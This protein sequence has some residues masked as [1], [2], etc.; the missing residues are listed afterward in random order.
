MRKYF[1][2]FLF[3]IARS[4]IGL[5]QN[6]IA[7]KDTTT[8]PVDSTLFFSFRACGFDYGNTAVRQKLLLK[9]DG[10]QDYRPVTQ[11]LG[12]A[13]S[14]EKKFLL[15]GFSPDAFRRGTSYFDDFGFRAGNRQFYVSDRPYTNVSLVLGM[16]Q[17]VNVYVRHAHPLGKNA[18]VAF[19]F[20]R[21]R[22]TGYYKRQNTNN[23][24]VNLNGWFRS[25]GRRYAFLFDFSWTKDAV[26][27]NGGIANDSSFFFAK[28]LDRQL[29]AVNLSSASTTCREREFWMKQFWSFG[30]VTDTV[31]IP[32]DSSG[33]VKTRILP[34]AAIVHTLSVSDDYFLYSDNALTDGFYNVILKDSSSTS[35][36]TYLWKMKNGL[37]F[38]VFNTK[39]D[40]KRRVVS[41]KIGARHELG[42]IRNDTIYQSFSN[43]YAD[44]SLDF[45]FGNNAFSAASLSG[46]YVASGYN[47]SDR[48]IHLLMESD[49]IGKTLN[50][51][52]E[53][54]SA[55]SHPDF[56]AEHYSGNNF[57]WS[58]SFH[59]SGH[60]EAK[61]LVLYRG[62]K[63]DNHYSVS[64]TFSEFTDAIYFG[65]DFRPAQMNG[66]ITAVTVSA[67][68]ETGLK[69]VRTRSELTWNRI[70]YGSPI[71]LPEFVARES[72]YGNFHIFHNGL[73]LQ[74][75]VDATWFSAFYADAYMPALSQFYVQNDSL[76]GNYLYIS[77]W[78]SFKIKP[79][80]VFIRADHANAAF[81]GRNYMIIPHYPQ[82]D[83]SLKFGLSWVFND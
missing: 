80:R 3:V 81:S 78:L 44:G 18:N 79:V 17:E 14:P 11:N 42:E 12:N 63:N 23:T 83:F 28:Q 21:I 47:A 16:K 65:Q 51:A 6:S 32:G 41:G 73:Q 37:W 77:P 66:N 7:K 70:Q 36:S 13:G 2:F 15:P 19:G 45:Y 74:F 72:L 9:L 53:A 30:T 33:T 31:K 26:A 43:I 5:T 49:T 58:N 46:W 57:R 24:S 67:F 29:V 48:L 27:E 54:T 82:N 52:L 76:S 20:E 69:M 62:K 59:Q 50:L 35:D 8:F 34:S 60:S 39:S 22:S 68:A 10:F 38:Q 1:L 55:L 61:M 40:G 4:S 56:L 25:P 71:R 64:A 75:G